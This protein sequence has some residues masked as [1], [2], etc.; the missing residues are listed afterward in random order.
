MIRPFKNYIPVIF[1]DD[2]KTDALAAKADEHINEWKQDL[3]DLERIMR[4]DETPSKYLDELNELL[5]ANFKPYDDDYTRR[6]KI[7]TAI[8]KHKYRGSFSL[9][10]KGRLDLI[11]G[12]SSRILK[13][14]DVAIFGT[15]DW[16]LLSDGGVA[17]SQVGTKYWAAMGV[18]GIDDDLGIALSGGEEVW[19]K[20][21]CYIDMHEGINTAVLTS[22]VLDACELEME[23]A[24]PAYYKIFLGYVDSLGEFQTYRKLD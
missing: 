7:Q 10:V 17:D 6:K 22:D 21:N 18:D 16:I 4:P 14:D 8:L 24:R 9:D 5:S 12:Y 23:D 3:R 19:V 1:R 20:V 11:T 2:P 13:E 15:D